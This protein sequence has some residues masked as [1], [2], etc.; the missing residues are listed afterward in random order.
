MTTVPLQQVWNTRKA[1]ETLTQC[2]QG[3]CVG[4]SSALMGFLLVFDATAKTNIKLVTGSLL[5]LCAQ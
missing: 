3:M 5:W 2:K 1:Y 4:R